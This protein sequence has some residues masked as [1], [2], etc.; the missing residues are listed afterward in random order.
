VSDNALADL[1]P[2]YA[3]QFA[4]FS[5]TRFIAWAAAADSGLRVAGTTPAKVVGS[6][7][8]DVDDERAHLAFFDA[9]GLLRRV[10][11]PVRTDAAGFSFVG[12]TFDS[13]IVSRVRIVSG[14]AAI[15]GLNA[16]IS[17]GGHADLVVMDDFISGEPHA[18]AV[19]GTERAEEAG[20]A[21]PCSSRRP[22]NLLRLHHQLGATMRFNQTRFSPLTAWPASGLRRWWGGPSDADDNARTSSVLQT[23]TFMTTTGGGDGMW[24]PA[25]S[26][27]LRPDGRSSQLVEPESGGPLRDPMTGRGPSRGRRCGPTNADTF[28]AGCVRRTRTGSMASD[29]WDELRRR[30]TR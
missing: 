4:A 2:A 22:R 29:S 10:H 15:T 5:P 14:Q 23:Q 19:I 12:V 21:S 26:L 30:L 9:G 28:V 17:A 3:D 13:P 1:N 11:A 6:W 18:I 27:A 25:R 8:S 20:R 24:P 16:D 7:S